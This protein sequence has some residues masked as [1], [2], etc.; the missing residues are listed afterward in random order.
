LH[1]KQNLYFVRCE[2]FTDALKSSRVISCVIV[3][4]KT[5]ISD[6]FSV[7][8]ILAHSAIPICN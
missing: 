5:Y 8:C 2:D 1:K 3:K 6:T 7:F 4:L